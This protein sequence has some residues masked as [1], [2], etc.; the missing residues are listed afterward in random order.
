MKRVPNIKDEEYFS[1]GS[2]DFSSS[3]KKKS[4]TKGRWSEE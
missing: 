4:E 1:Q 3:D 2:F